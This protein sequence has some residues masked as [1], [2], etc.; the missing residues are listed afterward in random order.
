MFQTEGNIIKH[1][2]NKKLVRVFSFWRLNL[3]VDLFQ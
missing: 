1:N 2:V 3:K